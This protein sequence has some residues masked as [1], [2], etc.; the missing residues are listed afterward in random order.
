MKRFISSEGKVAGA[1]PLPQAL[2][3]Q[4][5]RCILS[6]IE[7]I[8]SDLELHTHMKLIQMILKLIT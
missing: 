2:L 4:L 6:K 5:F 1:T 7:V 8:D 3:S